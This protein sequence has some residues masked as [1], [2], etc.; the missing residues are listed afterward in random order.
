[1]K[2][3]DKIVCILLAG[4]LSSIFAAVEGNEAS[5][6]T[7]IETEAE[8]DNGIYQRIAATTLSSIAEDHSNDTNNKHAFLSVSET[9]LASSQ[10]NVVGGINDLVDIEDD[11]LAIDSA[12]DNLFAIDDAEDDLLAIDDAEVSSEV[13]IGTT[14]PDSSPAQATER[15]NE[16][17]EETSP[18]TNLIADTEDKQIIENVLLGMRALPDNATIWQLFKAQ[19]QADFAPILIIIPR[20][21]KKLIARNAIKIAEKMR[22]II[23]G[24]MIPMLVVAG[25]VLGIAGNSVVY[26]GEDIIRFSKYLSSVADRPALDDTF[27]KQSNS[28]GDSVANTE[29]QTIIV[30]E[31]IGEGDVSFVLTSSVGQDQDVST[32]ASSIDDLNTASSE[33]V[34]IADKV[35]ELETPSAIVPIDMELGNQEIDITS[36]VSEEHS[37]ITPIEDEGV[38]RDYQG[39]SATMINE[40][41][42]EFD[43]IEL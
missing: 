41:G 14:V 3:R 32:A 30:A 16:E 9:L 4:A 40:D 13:C 27:S 21:I 22:V 15:T 23:G 28:D 42:E 11:L 31:D 10:E 17:I 7:T 8:V 26:I 33:K 37:E 25:R 34:T 20:P 19:V 36:I 38:S 29:S 5:N 35:E 6:S 2:L 24:P 43:F 1:M 18:D 12:E 39:E